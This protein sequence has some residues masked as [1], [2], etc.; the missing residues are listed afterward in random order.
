MPRKKPK[1][2]AEPPSQDQRIAAL[3]RR[4]QTAI[5]AV[6]DALEGVPQRQQALA[7]HLRVNKNL[8]RLLNALAQRDPLAVVHYLPGPDPLRQVIDATAE[9]GVPE[10]RLAEAREAIDAF[11]LLI[12]GEAGDRTYLDAILGAWLPEARQHVEV[13]HRQTIFKGMSHIKGA[14]GETKLVVAILFP[15]P[16]AKGS[17]YDVSVALVAGMLGLSRVRPDARITVSSRRTNMPSEVRPTT[18]DGSPVEDVADTRLDGFCDNPLPGRLQVRRVGEAAHYVIPGGPAG[19]GSSMDLIW[20]EVNRRCLATTPQP[21]SPRD[22]IST[23]IELPYKELV[24]DVLL[25]EGVKGFHDPK[26]MMH[27]TSPRGLV[28]VNDQS[29]DIDE[30]DVLDPLTP[31]RGGV[32]R[33]RLPTV[34]R[35]VDVL[36]HASHKLELDPTRLV[37][38]RLRMAHPLF[39]SQVSMVF[40]RT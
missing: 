1:T 4:L 17:P 6:L 12:R 14:F 24:L 8:T 35:Y 36:E 11:D 15:E 3:G 5:Q 27:Q 40:D 33:Y 29:R 20:A 31:L 18:L 28:D 13:L 19:K 2:K 38:W 16:P 26:L 21:D 9:H 30:I 39:G 23:I 37:G 32:N 7:R 10:R 22:A 34:P 25:A